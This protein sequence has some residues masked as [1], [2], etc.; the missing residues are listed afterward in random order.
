MATVSAVAHG[1]EHSVARQRHLQ[2]YA[3]FHAPVVGLHPVQQQKVRGTD[4][5]PGVERVSR[6]PEAAVG[7]RL[8]RTATR[9]PV[10]Q[11]QNLHQNPRRGYRHFDLRYGD[12]IRVIKLT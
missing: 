1:S 9:R 8:S 7:S 11:R 12:G 10:H 6:C 5:P 2:L 4:R 3:S